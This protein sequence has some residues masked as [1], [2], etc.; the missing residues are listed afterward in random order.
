MSGHTVEYEQACT[1]QPS[2]PTSNGFDTPVTHPRN[3][4]ADQSFA[5]P[6]TSP[7]RPPGDSARTESDMQQQE[8]QQDTP[9]V[10]RGAGRPKGS[11]NKDRRRPP[12][13]LDGQE[14]ALSA[15]CHLRRSTRKHAQLERY[16][17]VTGST[18]VQHKNY[19]F[20]TWLVGLECEGLA[21]SPDQS[22]AKPESPV[23]A[24]TAGS[25]ADVEV[26][27]GTLCRVMWELQESEPLDTELLALRAKH[28][29]GD[30]NSPSNAQQT[31]RVEQDGSGDTTAHSSPRSEAISQPHTESPHVEQ[32][33]GPACESRVVMSPKA[34]DN[35]TASSA[36]APDDAGVAVE[37]PTPSKRAKH[38]HPTSCL[39][40]SLGSYWAKPRFNSAQTASSSAISSENVSLSELSEPLRSEATAKPMPD[41]TTS[42]GHNSTHST[43]NSSSG[44]TLAFIQK[45]SK[46]NEHVYHVSGDDMTFSHDKHDV[47]KRIRTGSIQ[48]NVPTW[49][50]AGAYQIEISCAKLGVFSRTQDFKVVDAVGNCMVE[51]MDAGVWCKCEAASVAVSY[52]GAW[53][54]CSACHSWQHARCYDPNWSPDVGDPENMIMFKSAASAADNTRLHDVEH[55]MLSGFNGTDIQHFRCWHCCPLPR[56]SDGPANSF[57]RTSRRELYGLRVRRTLRMI[58]QNSGGYS[59]RTYDQDE[60]FCCTPTRVSMFLRKLVTDRERSNPTRCIDLGAGTGSLSRALPAGAVCVEKNS[61]RFHYGEEHDP[62]HRWIHEDVLNPTFIL[63]NAGKFD[64]VISNPDFEVALDFLYI[65]LQL[66]RKPKRNKNKNTNKRKVAETKSDGANDDNAGPSSAQAPSSVE[67]ATATE[68]EENHFEDD[69]HAADGNDDDNERMNGYM[70]PCGNGGGTGNSHSMTQQNGN[71]TA[72]AAAADDD[73]REG[74][75]KSVASSTVSSL[76]VTT[77]DGNQNPVRRGRGRPRNKRKPQGRS[78][79]QRKLIR[80]ALVHTTQQ[81][82]QRSS[83]VSSSSGGATHA[84]SSAG[85]RDDRQEM[86]NALVEASAQARKQAHAEVEAEAE[87]QAAEAEMEMEMEHTDNIEK[88]GDEEEGEDRD[89]DDDTEPR[90]IFLLPSDF[91]E[92]SSLRARLYKILDLHVHVEYKLGHLAYYKDSKSSKLTVDSFFELRVGKNNKFSHTTINARLAGMF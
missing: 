45:A 67:K 84:K 57:V 80:A 27:K 55:A 10:K 40:T 50:P 30:G 52:S 78:K 81:D 65:G 69:N 37:V 19:N 18:F 3:G 6:S 75:T 48:L 53:F 82:E 15:Q 85:T 43:G 5:A 68:R 89:D 11:K 46:H 60:K 25:A 56:S 35:A 34:T 44:M 16:D 2:L 17:P 83:S 59:R 51:D 13:L 49:V 58:S 76:S 9:A 70:N 28:A 8:Q 4:D 42:S 32:T 29:F 90:M 74:S 39:S 54:C 91:F 38:K 72:A 87:A 26:E 92:A 7:E 1:A 14:E 20:K 64:L 71:V 21:P 23:S 88:E 61:G 73:G 36:T 12:A 66:L 63:E 24:K 41:P 33:D 62:A 86:L 22:N 77:T 31:M 47:I 79:K